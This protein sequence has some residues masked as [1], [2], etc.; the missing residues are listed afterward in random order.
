MSTRNEISV[1][2]WSSS[3]TEQS[4]IPSEYTQEYYATAD[5]LATRLES[6]ARTTY[7]AARHGFYNRGWRVESANGES[8]DEPRSIEI[9]RNRGGA[10]GDYEVVNFREPSSGSR[11]EI[12]SYY[13]AG[14]DSS[15]GRYVSQFDVMRDGT[16][17][18]QASVL[19]PLGGKAPRPELIPDDTVSLQALRDIVDFA[20]LEQFDERTH[21]IN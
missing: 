14:S 1:N 2:A 17:L 5:Y 3:A 20:N 21:Y 10:S 16:L 11:L 19:P 12:A 6:L 15:G 13:F 8:I 4:G 9:V 7:L 18:A